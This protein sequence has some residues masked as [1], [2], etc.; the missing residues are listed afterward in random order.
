VP[1]HGA[2]I[3]IGSDATQN[4]HIVFVPARWTCVFPVNVRTREACANSRLL[5]F[6]KFLENRI[7]A[8]RVPDWIEP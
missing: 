7:R 6:A 4:C 1:K 8:Q 2:A 5:F 3:G